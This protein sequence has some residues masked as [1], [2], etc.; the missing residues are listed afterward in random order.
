MHDKLM[1]EQQRLAK[2]QAKGKKNVENRK[3]TKMTG[4]LKAMKAEKS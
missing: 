2:S 4:D 3:W 1:Q